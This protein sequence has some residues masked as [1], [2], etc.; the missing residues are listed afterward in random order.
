MPFNA[1]LNSV[2]VSDKGGYIVQ[3]TKKGESSPKKSIVTNDVLEEVEGL[4]ETLIATIDRLAELG[5]EK[6]IVALSFTKNSKGFYAVSS[7]GAEDPKLDEQQA[8]FGAGGGRS[9]GGGKQDI[10][11]MKSGVIGKMVAETEGVDINTPLD[12]LI[13]LG[14]KYLAMQNQLEEDIKSGA[15]TKS[16]SGGS[17]SAAPKQTKTPPAESVA[18]VK[19][20]VG[21]DAP[22]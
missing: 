3:Y 5:D 2:E 20:A 10:A 9:Y 1:T 4:E 11:G 13:T 14:R 17:T 8:K 6:P 18:N 21:G 22:F 16:V 7:I 12:E 19:K 15:K